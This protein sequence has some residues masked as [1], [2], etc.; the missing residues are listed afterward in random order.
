MGIVDDQEGSVLA[1]VRGNFSERRHIAIH[2][3]HALGQDEFRPVI[4]LIL[5]Q[6]LAEMGCVAMAVADLPHAGRL[7]AEMHAG[8]IETVGKNERLGA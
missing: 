5:I 1:R 7:A 4:C 8:V 2:R 6:K 3:K